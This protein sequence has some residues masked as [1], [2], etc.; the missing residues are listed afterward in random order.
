MRRNNGLGI[1]SQLEHSMHFPLEYVWK[2][3]TG[4]TLYGPLLQI[5]SQMVQLVNLKMFT[6]CEESCID[7]SKL[8][9]TDKIPNIIN[10]SPAT[11]TA[12][13]AQE[14]KLTPLDDTEFNY[15]ILSCPKH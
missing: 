4:K 12:F 3:T 6:S 2:T 9:F 8:Y 5:D 1:F 10:Q 13:L 14:S 7:K 15:S 11:L